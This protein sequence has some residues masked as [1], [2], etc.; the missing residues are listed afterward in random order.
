MAEN[1]SKDIIVIGAS[2][3]G[4]RAAARARRL[5]PDAKILVID[6]DSF[7]SYGACG[8][9]YFVSGD[10]HSADRLRETPYGIVRDT[11]FFRKSK[12]LEVIIETTVERIDCENKQVYCR[13]LKNGETSE[14]RYYK[15]VLATGA[16]P[17]MLP[18]VPTDSRRITTFKTLH[19][20]IDL[21]KS[22]EKREISK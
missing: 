21:R 6:R 11:D 7:I 18:G 22:L 8:M 20:A 19:D 3:A 15:L 16:N 2:A 10:I 17:I 14:Y 9:P 12:G 4:L 13:S 5:L 1:R